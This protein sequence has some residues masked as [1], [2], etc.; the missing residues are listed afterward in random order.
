MKKEEPL[1]ILHVLNNMGRGGA[2]TMIMNYYRN[3][4]R[5]KVQFDFL[6]HS[7]KKG[8]YD[9]E[10]ISLGGNLFYM[11]KLGPLNYFRYYYKL[12]RFFQQHPEYQIVHSHLNA[13]SG[14]ILNIAKN[15]GI[16]FRIAHAH[17]AVE[18]YVLSKLFKKNTDK[19]A[20]IKDFIQS[21][22]RSR[23]KKKATHFFAC[24]VKAGEWLFGKHN[25]S[26]VTIINNAIDAEKFSF[27]SNEASKLKNK[28]NLTGKKVIGHIARFNEQKNH[29]FLIKIFN[30]ICYR[31]E[32]VIL[33]LVGDGNLRPLIE[34][35]CQRLRIADKV[36]FLGVQRNIPELLKVFD[37]F[38]FP[39]LYE[40]LPV[41]LIEA[42]ASGLKI[43]AS[44]TITDEV[45]ITN[46]VT[47]CSLKDSEKLWAQMVLLNIDYN[48]E[49]T[50]NKMKKSQYDIFE[51]AKKLE[52]FYL[53]LI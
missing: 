11:P 45:D 33:M 29:F 20:T 31:K 17:L 48:R 53:K 50:F 21:L 25:L 12:C 1:R 52:K 24:G 4:N 39:S 32:N 35:E 43:V 7:T 40:G 34:K 22:I 9:D 3:V 47:F 26:Q 8:D 38:L 10:I 51:N 42:Q 6:L 30:E 37:L 46:L 5:N 13:M 36:I 41:T 14:F 19:K 23:T 2:E 27:N 44:D 16:P 49:N 28:F 15:S 18:P